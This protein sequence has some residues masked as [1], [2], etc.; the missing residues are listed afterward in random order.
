MSKITSSR[1]TFIRNS[2]LTASGLLLLGPSALAKSTN[3][4][5]MENSGLKIS[6]A[7][8]SLHK[9]LFADKLDNLDFA[10]KAREF[11]IDGMEYVSVFFEGKAKDIGYL[12]ELNKR[13]SDNGVKQLLIMVDREGDLADKD[14][15]A[16]QAAVENH[17]KWI[18]AAKF[19]GCHSIRVNAR[20]EG[21]REEQYA[22]AVDGLS[23]LAAIAQNVKINVIVENHGGL[24]SDGAWLSGVVREIGM[25][26]CGTLPDF[27]NFCIKHDG[28]GS[29]I[30]EYDRYKGVEELM[31]FARAVSAKSNVFNTEGD[32]TNIDFERMIKIVTEAGYQGYIGIEYEGDQLSE[33][34]GIIATKKLL[35]RYI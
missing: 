23:M 9:A 24:S 20:G 35:E 5:L 4:S 10:A 19:L 31:P 18:D 33:I 3:L 12:R 13:A 16:R 26:N 6:L 8:W 17:K 27:G 34:D 15:N 7:Q 2:G 22:Q 21:T 1:R 28:D 11:D 14:A 29:C 30:E 32:E 25:E